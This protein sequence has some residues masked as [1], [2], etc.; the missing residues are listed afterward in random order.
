ME[1]KGHW[2]RTDELEEAVST[3]ETLAEWSKNLDSNISYWK[4]VIL[5]THNAT[6]GFMVLALRGSD[7]LRPLRDDIAKK[8]LE[9][10]QNHT[11]Y[12]EE[13][14]DNFRNLYKKI[15]SDLML[16]FVHSKKFVSSK[17]Q[18]KSMHKLNSLRD[19]FIHF[20]PQSWSIEVSG[21]PEICSDCIDI[22]NFL[23]WESGNVTWYE[24]DQLIRAETA[25]TVIRKNLAS[26]NKL[27][28]Q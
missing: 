8:W 2:F 10:H 24:Q 7:R 26:V 11:E 21:L 6:Q 12:P 17:A 15:K 23:G 16:F 22:I 19:N 14:L 13:K 25:I 20:L 3:L 5:A 27:Y 18:D 9:A 1:S 28:G 4:W